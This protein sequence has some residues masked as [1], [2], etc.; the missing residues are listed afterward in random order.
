M[1][2]RA[3]DSTSAH[4]QVRDHDGHSE[5]G[6]VM[7][8]ETRGIRHVHLFVSDHARS[9]AF[10]ERVFGMQVAFR[11][12]DILFLRSPGRSD[13]LALHLAVTE[14]ERA[15]VG[16]HGGYEHFGITVR[17]RGHLDKAIALA[18]EAGGALVDRGEHAPGVPYAYVADPDGYVIEI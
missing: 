8:V 7:P 9:V 3:A 15:R 14:D 2:E 12:G 10:Y 1:Q 5:W 6:S 4:E 18:V 17:D 16:Q 11:D 13:D